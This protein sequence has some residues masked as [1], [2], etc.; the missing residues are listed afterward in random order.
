MAWPPPIPPDTRNNQTPQL[1]DHV[2]DHAQLAV[3]VGQLVA[4]A[5]PRVKVSRS[6]LSTYNVPNDTE[7]RIMPGVVEIPAVGFTMNGTICTYDG[8]DPVL[9]LIGASAKWDVVS[10]S[11]LK[12]ARKVAVQLND[13]EIAAQHATAS[14]G[15]FTVVACHV[16]RV[17]QPGDVLT[18]HVWHD[19]GSALGLPGTSGTYFSVVGLHP[20]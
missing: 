12:G 10:G 6:G 7:S 18:Y 19:Y 8:P 11:T 16:V 17:L 5:I 9:A 14:L 1:D 4:A 13:T 20:V 2:A 15:G 3:A